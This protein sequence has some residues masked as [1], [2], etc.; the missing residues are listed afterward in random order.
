MTSDDLRV[1]LTLASLAYTDEVP[2][3]NEGVSGQEQRFM[4]DLN[5]HAT[6][7]LQAVSTTRDWRVIWVGLS[8]DRERSNLAY[9]AQSP[10]ANTYAIVLRG[11]DFKLFVDALE[12]FDVSGI[13]PFDAGGNIAAG[14]KTAFDLVMAS[15]YQAGGAA[16]LEGTTL[17]GAL[18]QLVDAAPDG[19]TT[20]FYVS[21]HS[22]GGAIAT[23]VSLFLRRQQWSKPVTF[24]VYTFAAPTAGDAHFADAFDAAFG[25]TDPGVDSSWR[26][27][28]AYDVVPHAWQSVELVAAYYPTPPGPAA[29]LAIK[30]LLDG[31]NACAA[32]HSYVQPNAAGTP[33]MVLINT[34][35]AQFDAT[36]TDHE[37][38]AFLGQLGF[39]HGCNTYLAGLEAPQ[40]QFQPG[41]AC[42]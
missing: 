23:T 42:I 30:M 29:T 11:T 7:G 15:V 17:L 8:E 16:W 9:I 10:T 5:T 36:H 20:T 38:S 26:C 19:V 27:V 33:G 41:V 6:Y 21:G 39:Q 22:L 31:I 24:Q 2:L 4:T 13:L 37:L 34:Q 32:G 40:L 28:N 12:D 1:M 25:A 18:G 3:P 35:Y 14:A